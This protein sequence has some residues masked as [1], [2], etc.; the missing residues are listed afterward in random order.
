MLASVRLSSTSVHH[1]AELGWMC[2]CR[3]A[4]QLSMWHV[5][6]QGCD[7]LHSFVTTGMA[8][9]CIA[10]WHFAADTVPSW[11]AL[12]CIMA[13]CSRYSPFM[14]GSHCAGHTLGISPP[15]EHVAYFGML[16]QTVV[17]IHHSMKIPSGNTV[18]ASTMPHANF[19]MQA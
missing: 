8:M 4:W 9:F 5:I 15:R 1:R 18:P 16:L 13:L 6:Q 2:L 3:Q 7:S 17:E 12:H 14:A 11:Q 19:V 10:S